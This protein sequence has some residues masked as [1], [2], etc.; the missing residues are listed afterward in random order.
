MTAMLNMIYVMAIAM[1]SLLALAT[2]VDW[3]TPARQPIGW[4]L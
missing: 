3:R 4:D 2:L 1:A